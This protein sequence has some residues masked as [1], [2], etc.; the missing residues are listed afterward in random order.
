MAWGWR[1]NPSTPEEVTELFGLLNDIH[2]FVWRG[3]ED[4][5]KWKFDKD[6]LFSVSSV[7]KLL[8]SNNMGDPN[9]SFKCFKWKG[10]MPL[11]CKIMVWRDARNRLPTIAELIKR[12]VSIQHCCCS[13]CDEV[14]EITLHLFTGC[15]FSQEV[16]FRI[17]AWC[18][19]QHGCIFDISYLLQLLERNAS[20]KE[21]RHTLRGIVYAT[22][23]VL[24]NERNDRI[25]NKK[26]RK[27]CEV[28]EIVKAYDEARRMGRWDKK[29]E[30]YTNRK[31]NPVAD[32][33][34][35]NFNDLLEVIPT[36]VELYS[37]K[38]VDKTYI[39]NMEKR[40]SEVM[41][42]SL[43]KRDE[44]RLQKNV[45]KMVDE[46]K[47]NAE[48]DNGENEQKVNEL[49]KTAGEAGEES[50]K[51][52]DEK[53]KKQVE[54]AVA[55]KQQYIEEVAELKRKMDE[56]EQDNNKLHSYHAS[57]YV[58]ERIF[59]IKLDDK[60]SERNTKGI[61]SEYNQVPPLFEKNFTFYDDE[62]LEKAFNMVDQLL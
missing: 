1:S 48:E 37:K 28:V 17:E 33:R 49:Q 15:M 34:S 9:S 38:F 43:R 26:R 50:Q 10:W 31:G 6:G 3:G 11:K 32:S 42:A 35:V 60:D 46:L 51:K 2:D 7:K 23:W 29:R 18:R 47:K 21:S 58:L 25:F 12:G 41:L 56:L 22:F 55:E 45:E 24:W 40:I 4:D 36:S 20:S 44:E 59:N 16:W 19:I 39:P 14:M 53:L 13:F 62:K 61:G 30:C 5:W 8:S 54:E 27:P 52:T 57:S